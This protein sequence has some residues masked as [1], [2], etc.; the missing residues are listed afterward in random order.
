[1][2]FQILNK[3][4]WHGGLDECVIV[5]R[6]RGALNDEKT[7]F[8]SDVTEVKKSYFYYINK[9]NNQEVVIPLH[10]ILRVMVKGKVI[11]EKRKIP[12]KK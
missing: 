9:I 10:R 2:V 5:I 6:H 11:W 8:G 12:S 7:I 1:M 3:L 4:K